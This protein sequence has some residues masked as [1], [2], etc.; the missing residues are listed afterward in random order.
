MSGTLTVAEALWRA[1]E[2]EGVEYAFGIPGSNI[3]PSTMPTH[4]SHPV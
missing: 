4:G 2:A 3:L 1:L